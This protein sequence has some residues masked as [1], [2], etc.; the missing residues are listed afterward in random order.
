MDPFQDEEQSQGPGFNPKSLLRIFWRRKWLFLIPFVVCL[1]MAYVAIKTM[2]PI[3]ASSGVVLIKFNSMNSRLLEDPSR[4]YG[5]PRDIDK[6]AYLEMDMMLTSVEFME[7]VVREMGLQE[8]E[9]AG[10]PDSTIT[11]A[12][13]DRA[14]RRAMRKLNAMVRIKQDGIRLFRIEVRGPSPQQAYQ[15]A[16]F[17]LPRFVDEYRASQAATSTSTRDFLENQLEVYRRSLLEAERTLT[18]YQSTMASAALLGNPINGMNLSLAQDNLQSVRIR[19]SGQDANE[20]AEFARSVRRAIGSVPDPEPY[21]QDTILRSTIA[22]MEDLGLSLQL[23]A[24]GTASRTD[25]DTR[26]GQLRVRLSNRIDE[27]V[28]QNMP[29]VP[30][31]QRNVVSQYIYFT[32]FRAGTKRVIDKLDRQI[33]DFREFTARQPGQ[34]ARLA[35]LQDDVASA[36]ELVQSLEKEITRQTMNLEASQ[37]EIGMQIKVHRSPRLN[38]V[39]VE[40]NKMKLMMMGVVLSLGIGLGLVVLAI[41]LDRS[42]QTVE[43]IERTLGVPVIGTIPMIQDDHFERKKKVRFLR[44]ATI[45]LGILAVSAVGFLVVYPRLS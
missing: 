14:V 23:F 19:Y 25:L 26:L 32:M 16:A 28:A 18:D 13:V 4:R 15:L 12:H 2:T 24:E 10:I 17:L 42:F 43:D 29:N 45:I 33:R 40:P 3:Y 6:M 36:G 41:F 39:P 11:D 8:A 30:Y 21:N 35:E 37:S 1:S 44:W 9:L 38:G 5:R 7:K 31:V 27:L 20:L 22:E 34:S